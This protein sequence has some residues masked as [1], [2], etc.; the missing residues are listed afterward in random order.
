M[1][2]KVD[3]VDASGHTQKQ[4]VD[5]DDID[6]YDA[7]YMPIVVVVIF[8]KNGDLLIHKRSLTKS[9]APGSIDHVCGGVLTG[10]K[11]VD[12]ALRETREEVGVIPHNLKL[13]MAGVNKYR[14]YRNLFVGTSEEEPTL[15]EPN[16]IEWIAWTPRRELEA[17]RDS[18]E[19][20][21][22]KEF[23]EEVGLAEK[24][25]AEGKS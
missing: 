4:S 6:A 12:A 7:L 17:K 10:E 1:G 19:W 23:W 18:G 8:N 22:S 14:R 13:V 15:S 11:I 9:T 3:L 20:Q 25:L 21:F 2:E 5:R 24:K 16:D